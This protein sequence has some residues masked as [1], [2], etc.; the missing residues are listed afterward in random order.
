M[1]EQKNKDKKTPCILIWP[2]QNSNLL[3]MKND[4][5]DNV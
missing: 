5:P 2:G 4:F 3:K 1:Y